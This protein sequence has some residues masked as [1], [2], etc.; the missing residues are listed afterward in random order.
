LFGEAQARIIVS[1]ERTGDVERIAAVHRVPARPHWRGSRRRSTVPH[2]YSGGELVAPVQQIARAYHD[3]IP[4]IMTRVA[5]ADDAMVDAIS[6]TRAAD[7]CA[8]SLAF[9]GCRMRRRSFTSVSI[10]CSTA[11][12]I[13]RH[14]RDR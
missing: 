11:A 9:R 7:L 13:G 8:G 12:G 2:R 14:R 4:S 3:A 1:D 6:S 10:H 5:V